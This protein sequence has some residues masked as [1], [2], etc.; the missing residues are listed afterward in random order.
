MST[1]KLNLQM[2]EINQN[3][4]CL[5]WRAF[6]D[7]GEP[8]TV[9]DLVQLGLGDAIKIRGAITGLCSRGWLVRVG[10]H[11]DGHSM[12]YVAVSDPQQ[13]VLQEPRDV[14]VRDA[15]RRLTAC[16][17]KAHAARMSGFEREMGQALFELEK[18][19]REIRDGL[20]A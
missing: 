4:S 20:K 15:Q 19:L 3:F 6:R 2:L 13:Q 17:K 12:R 8:C 10:V 16:S 18:E 11:S 7:F 9:N 1:P 14:S 5:V